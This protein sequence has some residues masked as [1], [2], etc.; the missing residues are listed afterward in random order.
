MAQHRRAKLGDTVSHGGIS[1]LLR[2]LREENK[3]SSGAQF[4]EDLVA[5]THVTRVAAVL[6][7]GTERVYDIQVSGDH[8]YQTGMLLSHNCE[9]SADIVTTSWI[10]DELKAQGRFY[11]QCLKSRDTAPFERFA[12]RVEFHCRRLLVDHSG[13]DMAEGDTKKQNEDIADELDEMF[14]A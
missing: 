1:T 7:T 2:L 3:W 8:E 6:Q 14:A 10:D 5:R 13:I 4:L 9:R 11:M 12:V